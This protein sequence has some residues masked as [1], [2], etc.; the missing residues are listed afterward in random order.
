MTE[1]GRP[2][3]CNANGKRSDREFHRSTSSSSHRLKRRSLFAIRESTVR[4]SLA[5]WLGGA[6]LLLLV[7]IVSVAVIPQEWP[8]CLTGCTANDVEL[9]GVTPEILGSPTPDGIV[10]VALWGSLYFNRKKS[11]TS[12]IPK[13]ILP[14]RLPRD[15]SPSLFNGTNLKRFSKLLTSE[16]TIHPHISNSIRKIWPVSGQSPACQ[17]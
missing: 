12:A 1:R 8:D 2:A 6:S 14:V 10:E 15:L 16:P 17:R 4:G 9:I 11:F 3:G 5:R 13:R 7:S